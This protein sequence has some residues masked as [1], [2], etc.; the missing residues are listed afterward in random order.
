VYGK[1]TAYAKSIATGPGLPVAF[2]LT[3]TDP[4][5]LKITGY[6]LATLPA[7]GTLTDTATGQPVSGMV[8]SPNLTYTPAA[9][10]LGAVDSFTYTVYNGHMTSSAVTVSITVYGKPTAGTT[11]LTTNQETPLPLT[12]TGSDRFGLPLSNYT[13]VTLPAHGTLTDTATGQPVNLGLLSSRNL[14]YTPAV[15]FHDVD[16]FTFT[17]SNGYLT[18]DPGT[19]TITV[20]GKPTAK[21][22]SLTSS[23]GAPISLTLSG[24]DPLGLAITAYT[25]ATLPAHGTL[26]YTAT[27]QPVSLGTLTSPNLTFT[28]TSGYKGT[29]AFTFTVYNGHLTSNPGTVSLTMN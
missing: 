1:P 12:L 7:H 15:G 14:T 25:L 16:K 21:A 8:T 29:D 9:G 11:T 19:I 5:G 20:Y 3:G 28:P 22:Q 17:T 27:G 6:T 13:L 26:T 23:G 18:S 4:L 10:F 24:T 2:T